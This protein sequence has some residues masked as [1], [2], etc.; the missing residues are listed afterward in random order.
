MSR[1]FFILISFKQ[2]ESCRQ[3]LG[4]GLLDLW[5]DELL[6]SLGVLNKLAF[7]QMIARARGPDFVGESPPLALSMLVWAARVHA[8]IEF[9]GSLDMGEFAPL[10]R[11]VGTIAA[12]RH[13]GVLEMTVGVGA[14][15]EEP[16]H[17]LG[18]V[19]R[20]DSGRWVAAAALFVL[21]S[22]SKGTNILHVDRRAF[23]GSGGLMSKWTVLPSA[24][25]VK[26][27][28]I[29][30]VV[31]VAIHI[32]VHVHIPA[33]CSLRTLVLPSLVE[34]SSSTAPALNPIEERAALLTTVLKSRVDGRRSKTRHQLR[35]H[36]CLFL[37]HL[38]DLHLVFRA[39]LAH[40]AIHIAIH[41]STSTSTTSAI[42]HLVTTAGAT[43][44]ATSLLSADTVQ[45][46]VTVTREIPVNLVEH[47]SSSTTSIAHRLW[48][49]GSG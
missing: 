8:R 17:L 30:G 48:S 28:D 14:V 9:A 13:V 45:G 4:L 19:G 36:S 35:H 21:A 32:G 47:V 42:S 1:C 38:H 23:G 24:S 18:L 7:A 40:A 49:S 11:A 2:A 25:Y 29:V 20:L 39:H 33:I 15:R 10:L 41:G 44:A 43:D 12:K 27:A 31:V 34:T 37:Q 3:V 46:R 5:F 26:P 22:G 16:A 6:L